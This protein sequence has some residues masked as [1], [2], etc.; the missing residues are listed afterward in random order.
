M[1]RTDRAAEEDARG[2]Q[3]KEISKRSGD[4]KKREKEAAEESS[5]QGA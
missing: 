1:G 5:A 2:L 3:C 4:E